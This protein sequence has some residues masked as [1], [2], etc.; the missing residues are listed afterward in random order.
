VPRV[1]L[2]PGDHG[3]LPVTFA[4]NTIQQAVTFKNAGTLTLSTTGCHVYIFVDGSDVGQIKVVDGFPP[5]SFAVV[6]GQNY[7]VLVA[8][9]TD[10]Q[11]SGTIHYSF[12]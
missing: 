11:P 1:N 6:T 10:A 9:T 12:A 3:D 4:G 2:G 5:K 8:G 7:D